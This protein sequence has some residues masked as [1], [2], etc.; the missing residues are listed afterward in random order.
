VKTGKRLCLLPLLL[1]CMLLPALAAEV[2]LR[3]YTLTDLYSF[4]DRGGTQHQQLFQTLYFKLERPGEDRL[5]LVGHLR[6]QG[7]SANDFGDSSAFKVHNLYLRWTHGHQWDVRLGRQFLAEGVGFGAYDVLRLT[8]DR[9]FT[10]WGGLAAPPDRKAE[11]EKFDQ[12]P[13]FGASFRG[14]SYGVQTLVSYFYREMEGQ[15]YLHRAGLSGTYTISP[16]LTANA[17]LYFNLSG[18]SELHRARLF[19]RYTPAADWR[20]FGEIAVG[21]PQLPINSPFENV[22]IGTFELLRLGG[23]YRVLNQYWVNVH[24]QSLISADQPNT[25][26]GV[27]LEGTWGNFGYRQRFGDFGDESGLFGSARFA[28]FPCAEVYASA[29]YSTYKFDDNTDSDEQTQAMAGLRLVPLKQL[30]ID[31]SLQGLKN[32]LF[33]HDVRGLLRIKW[34]FTN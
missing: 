6:Y 19:M 4:K 33:E 11:L 18:P 14:V 32:R 17:L 21:T 28:V 24:A 22:E 16:E 1:C 9:S 8:W 26:L 7:D 27:A 13:A 30:E 3:G 34:S 2:H 31:A 10:F 29:D 5:S 23:A 25:T 20:C 15:R 12:A